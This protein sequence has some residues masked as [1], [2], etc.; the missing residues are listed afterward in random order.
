MNA[1]EPVRWRVREAALGELGDEVD[2][3]DRL[4]GARAALDDEDD[5]LLVL[6]GRRGPNR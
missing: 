4:P 5:L 1:F 3:D 2:G 6:A